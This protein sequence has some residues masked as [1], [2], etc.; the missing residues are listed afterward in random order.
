MQLPP[1]DL[2]DMVHEPSD[3]QLED[4]ME[5]VAAEARRHAEAAR[6]QLMVRLRAEITAI[7]LPSR[8]E[9]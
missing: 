9:A 2:N 1:F 8:R 6:A 3:E 7:R 5:A 4:L